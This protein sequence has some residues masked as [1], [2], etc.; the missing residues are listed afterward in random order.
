MIQSEIRK[1]SLPIA[2]V[3]LAI[4]L[5]ACGQPSDSSA[6]A[7]ADEAGGMSQDIADAAD[8]APAVPGG[9]PEVV[10]ELMITDVKTG[11]GETAAAGQNIIVHYTGWLYDPSQPENKG[12]KFDSSVDRGQPFVFPLGAG[13]VIQ[14]WDQGFD[15]MQIGGKRILIIPP[16]MGYGERGAGADIPPN[17]TLLFE[18]DLLGIQ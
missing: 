16:E 7:P 4:L 1:L 3:M 15:G 2:T 10:T 5:G 13:R 11:D 17:A 6:A 14:G 9:G 18:V 12:N 8:A